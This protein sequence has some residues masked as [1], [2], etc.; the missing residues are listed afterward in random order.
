[1]KFMMNEALTVGTRDGATIEMAE[2]AGHENFFLF[3]LTADQ[4]AGTR[5]WYNPQGHYDNGPEI[6]AALDLIFSDHF[7]REDSQA[8]VRSL[9]THRKFGE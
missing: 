5:P 4:V 9:N 2:E 8:T 1:M 3:G 6:R 7:S